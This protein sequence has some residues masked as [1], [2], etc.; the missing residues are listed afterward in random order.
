[1]EE[2]NPEKA[3]QKYYGTREK[4]EKR[5]GLKHLKRLRMLENLIRETLMLKLLETHFGVSKSFLL[6]RIKC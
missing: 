2:I 5:N 1:M 6:T 4:M 3:M